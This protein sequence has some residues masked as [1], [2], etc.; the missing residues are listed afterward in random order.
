MRSPAGKT[1]ASGKQYITR[2]A[3]RLMTVSALAVLVL[4]PRAIPRREQA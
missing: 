2:T 1:T 4:V 3:M